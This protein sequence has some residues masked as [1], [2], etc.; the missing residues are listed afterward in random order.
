[1]WNPTAELLDENNL[2]AS[3]FDALKEGDTQAFKEILTAHIEA[4]V[5]TTAAKK[6]G[7]AHRTLY[8]ALSSKGNPS[9]ETIAKIVQMACAA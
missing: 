7:L 6:H 9:L 1:M 2:K 5:K 3:L 8:Q 4:K